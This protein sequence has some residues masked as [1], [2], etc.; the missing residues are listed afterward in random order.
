MLIHSW[1]WFG[2]NDRITLEQIVQTGAKSIVTALHDIPTGDVWNPEAI[3]TRKNL[4]TGAGLQWSVVESVPVHEDI[5]RRTGNYSEFIENFKTTLVNL[6]KEGIPVVC[7]NFM[8]AL[9]WSRTDLRFKFKDGS[10]SLY[11]NF[12]HFA[13]IDIYILKRPGAGPSY[14]PDIQSRAEEFYKKLDKKARENLKNTF[15]LGFPGSGESFTLEQVLERIRSYDGIDKNA[16][17]SNLAHFLKEVVPVAEEAGIRLA[18]HP[19]DPPW[20]LM[21]MPRV[22]STLE[23]A[24]FIINVM[25]SRSNGITLCTGSL[26]AAYSNDMNEMAD[27]LAHRINYAHLRNVTRDEEL[28]FHEDYFF[29]GDV[30][31]FRI[32]KTLIKEDLRRVDEEGDQSGIPLRPDH[33]AQ[34]LGDLHES[35]YPGYSLYGRL[36]NLAEIRGL[37]IGIRNSLEDEQS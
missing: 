32:M 23:D 11:F 8:P 3:R 6:G 35:N 7:Y 34:L 24:E 5:K 17:R 29:N 25:D 19:D 13:A 20:P 22:M 9:D 18:I 21:G 31:M 30:D 2:P 1:R 16:F 37:E 28:N 14:P 15:L 12:V 10:E 26:G 4:I 36:K 33:G 27:R